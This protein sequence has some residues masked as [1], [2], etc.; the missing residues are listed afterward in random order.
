MTNAEQE[1]LD[2]LREFEISTRGY[3]LRRG[4][5]ESEL[6]SAILEAQWQLL[7]DILRAKT[8]IMLRQKNHRTP[9]KKR[10]PA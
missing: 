8:S 9:K 3:F 7:H 10:T 4:L 1:A 2:F 5:V 6:S